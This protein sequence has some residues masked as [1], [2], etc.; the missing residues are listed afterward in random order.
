MSIKFFLKKNFYNLL[1]LNNNKKI[2][3]N[4]I[5][6]KSEKKNWVLNQ[7]ANEYK[8]VFQNFTK[9]VSLKEQDIYMSNDVHL[10]IMS[11]YYALENL[12]NYKNKIYFPYFHGSTDDTQHR[13]SLEIIKKNID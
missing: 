1:N 3:K 6:I 12:K 8:E 2:T 4:F 9:N 7:I 11:K 13:Q 5:V 10:F